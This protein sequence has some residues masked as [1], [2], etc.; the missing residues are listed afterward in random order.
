MSTRNIQESSY[1]STQLMDI[2]AFIA[3]TD[4]YL[5]AA[6]TSSQLI[7]GNIYNIDG[8]SIGTY[9]Y[10]LIWTASTNNGYLTNQTKLTTIIAGGTY[11]T[12]YTAA[13]ATGIDL[14]NAA[15]GNIL[16][17]LGARTGLNITTISPLLNSIATLSRVPGN[18][19]A[20]G[21]SGG[22]SDVN[23]TQIA[24]VNVPA[25]LGLPISDE[26]FAP[27]TAT[28][29]NATVQN[30]AQTVSTAGCDTVVLTVVPTGTVTPGVITFECFDGATW[31]PIRIGRSSQY[32]T[33]TTYALGGGQQNW[34]I[35]LAGYTQYRTRLSTAITG[36]G[37]VIV[38]AIVSSAPDVGTVTV[39]IDTTTYGQAVKASSLPV[40]IA[41]DQTT[42]TF[43]H[44]QPS[45]TTATSFT[46]LASNTS[47]KFLEI[48]NNSSANIL[49]NLNNGTLT[50][51]VP[52]SSNLGFVL[53]P[54]SAWYSP[55]NVCPTA[56]ITG[57][58]TSGSTINTI[59][60]IEGT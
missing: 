32:A 42:S 4:D 41:S 43:T 50:G 31:V 18:I 53:T 24:G 59:S 14:P 2:G 22:G 17:N 47:R 51:I 46:L 7:T 57:Y 25:N 13:S 29:T 12:G 52:T 60:V 49:I 21:G 26:Y 19:S 28:W 38:T 3:A 39:G 48:Q 1:D 27:V 37:S 15:L 10:T 56:A 55:P 11:A 35:N 36:G 8:Q 33:E 45:V 23:I 9:S 34:Q 40:T 16:F 20:S 54:G 5:L 44:T 58:Q 6:A 30:T